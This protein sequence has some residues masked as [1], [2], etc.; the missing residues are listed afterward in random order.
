MQRSSSSSTAGLCYLLLIPDVLLKRKR[1]EKSLYAQHSFRNL[2]KKLYKTPSALF[3][4][5]TTIA[6]FSRYPAADDDDCCIVEE[7]RLV[8]AG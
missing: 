5:H 6:V 1:T 8:R 3:L 7:D 2:I 4:P